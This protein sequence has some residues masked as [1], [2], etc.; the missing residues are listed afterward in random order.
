MRVHVQKARDHV[1]ARSVDRQRRAT[2]AIARGVLRGRYDSFLYAQ[3]I[4]SFDYPRFAEPLP[5]RIRQRAAAAGCL[6][7]KSTGLDHRAAPWPAFECH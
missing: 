5:D 3:G 2:G 6:V 4:R 1:L 7:A